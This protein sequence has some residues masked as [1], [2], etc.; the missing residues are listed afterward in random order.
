MVQQGYTLVKVRDVKPIL[1]EEHHVAC[2][3]TG[4]DLCNLLDMIVEV[5]LR[6]LNCAG[7]AVHDRAEYGG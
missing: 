4:N 1:K 3:D 7:C 2:N 5:K 6:T